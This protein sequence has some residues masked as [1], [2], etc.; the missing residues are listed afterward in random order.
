VSDVDVLSGFCYLCNTSID[1]DVQTHFEQHHRTSVRKPKVP[2][3][4]WE[5]RVSNVLSELREVRESE[6]RGR[7]IDLVDNI[8]QELYLV[9]QK[10]AQEKGTP[11]MRVKEG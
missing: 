9:R 7:Q 8:L 4:S 3:M 10:L 11:V 2:I 6:D 5:H 1:A